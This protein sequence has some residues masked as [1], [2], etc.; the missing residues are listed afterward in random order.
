MITNGQEAAVLASAFTFEHADR[1]LESRAPQC[2]QTSSG[3]SSVRIGMADNDS[4]QPGFDDC[5]RA[6]TGATDVA[7]RLESHRHGGAA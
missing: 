7:T 6:R 4:T 2:A 5:T 3:D 1:N